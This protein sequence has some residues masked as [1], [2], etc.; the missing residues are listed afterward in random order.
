MLLAIR[1]VQDCLTLIQTSAAK[2]DEARADT[3]VTPLQLFTYRAPPMK[4]RDLVQL[5]GPHSVAACAAI[6]GTAVWR[7]LL[8]GTNVFLQGLN[9]RR[10]ASLKGARR[11]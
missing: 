8:L 2:R 3:V 11:E 6:I 10:P 5:Y 7:G 4:W 9:Q 1:A